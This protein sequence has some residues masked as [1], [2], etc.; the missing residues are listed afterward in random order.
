[1]RRALAVLALPALLA[2]CAP[3]ATFTPITPLERATNG[4]Y[5]GEGNG[6]TGRVPYRLTLTVQQKAGRAS[7][8]LQ[9]LE[10]K[11]TYAGSGTIQAS[12]GEGGA[13][14]VDL[15]MNFYENG[16]KYRAALHATIQNRHII[17]R[18]RT[19]LLGQKLFPY[20]INLAK[21][22]DAAAPTPQP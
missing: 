14:G 16:D 7:G 2:A 1:M 21:L 10:S 8:V 11:K 17:G 13:G 22:D 12:A 19:V 5:Q 18:L 20:N 3:G 4:L 9:N 15:D 6:L